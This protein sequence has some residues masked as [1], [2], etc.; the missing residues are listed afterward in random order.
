ME[1]DDPEIETISIHLFSRDEIEEGQLGYSLDDKDNTL[2]GNTEGDW[3]VTWF[4][5]G[6]DEGLGELYL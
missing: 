2:V 1:V 4:V 5:I 3:K 6:Y